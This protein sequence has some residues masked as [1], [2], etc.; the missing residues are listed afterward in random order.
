MNKHSLGKQN[1]VGTYHDAR[2]KIY[3]IFGIV[4]LIGCLSIC[5]S[6]Q[7]K[8]ANKN[9][10]FTKGCVDI[11]FIYPEEGAQLHEKEE[12]IVKARMINFLDFPAEKRNYFRLYLF[13]RI[14]SDEIWHLHNRCQVDSNG[15]IQCPAWMPKYASRLPFELVLVALGE[16]IESKYYFKQWNQL[17]SKYLGKQSIVVHR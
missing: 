17:P 7:C 8:G 1:S 4:L 14:T 3:T 11:G 10:K 2:Y 9:F 5:L 15:Y 6:I 13:W 12:T 16:T